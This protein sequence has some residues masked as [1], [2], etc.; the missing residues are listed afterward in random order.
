MSHWDADNQ[1]WVPEGRQHGQ[2]E[3]EPPPQGPSPYGPQPTP[4]WDATA[5]GP[6]SPRPA[7]PDAVVT[8]PQRRLVLSLIAV[9]VCA[10]LGGGTWFLVDRS[11][12]NGP[13]ALSGPAS[14]TAANSP[15]DKTTNEPTDEPTIE[16]TAEPTATDSPSVSDG[17]PP[18]PGYTRFDD[19]AGF[20]VDV[21]N[22]WQ[23]T[24]GDASVT[25]SS[26]DGTY[27]LQVFQLNGPE[28]T[29]YDSAAE[30]KR[31]ASQQSA[32]DLVS[33]EL[34]GPDTDSDAYLE[35]TYT[36]NTAGHRRIMDH[37]ATADDDAMYAVLVSAPAG[38]RTTQSEILRNAVNSF[39]PTAYCPSS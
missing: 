2:P 7:G 12:D 23:R 8:N 24:T 38:A 15:T 4:P 16:P 6:D 39:C 27:F 22:G 11:S 26:P 19:E 31:L 25:Y 32:F 37:R 5:P 3:Y 28:P 10:V 34:Q 9:L 1:R 17:D 33:L 36:S 18:T 20:T 35:Y 21:R 13:G 29:P 30:A 14:P